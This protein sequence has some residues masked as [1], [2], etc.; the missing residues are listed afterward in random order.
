VSKLKRVNI[1]CGQSPTPGWLNYDNS[2]SVRLARHPLLARAFGRLPVLARSQREF[3][4]F[5]ATRDIH[6][7]DAT[8]HIP[9]PD[10]SVEVLYTSHTV[11]HMDR[12]DARR[13]AGEALR[14]LAPG[15]IIRVAVPDLRVLVNQYLDEENADT[16]M[17]RTWLTRPRARSPV[18]RLQS[19][20]VGER[21]HLW[22]YDGPSMVRFLS[23]MGF[24][25]PLVCEAG[26]TRIP[27]PDPL[28]LRER[29]EETVYVEAYR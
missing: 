19:L 25:E 1:G 16:F 9:L 4:E 29:A 27:D 2:L 3:V 28:N 6:W 21:H 11:E 12:E 17:E 26:T 7:A 20:L 15:G 14:V 22:M 23:A 13:F 24:R 5:A 8:K 10:A 18:E